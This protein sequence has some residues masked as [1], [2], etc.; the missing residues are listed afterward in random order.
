M[1][2]NIFE[3]KHSLQSVTKTFPEWAEESFW[4]K[5]FEILNKFLTVNIVSGAP[6]TTIF[7]LCFSAF[8][9]KKQLTSKKQ[10]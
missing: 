10:K 4:V 3:S 9:Q 7:R 8:N 1:F 2:G 6:K 5:I